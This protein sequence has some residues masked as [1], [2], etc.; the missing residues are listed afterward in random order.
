MG[1]DIDSELNAQEQAVLAL[2]L[3]GFIGHVD[4]LILQR[5]TG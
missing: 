1:R 5:E 2:L 4:F 3:C